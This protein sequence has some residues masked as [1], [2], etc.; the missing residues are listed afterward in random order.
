[1]I[2]YDKFWETMKKKNMTYYKLEKHYGISTNTLRKLQ[3]NE[4]VSVYTL[5]KLCY[6]L[7]CGLSDIAEFREDPNEE[8]PQVI[9]K[10]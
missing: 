7:G 10:R 5:N 6:I 9:N 1:M 4:N 8:R 2:V 3:K